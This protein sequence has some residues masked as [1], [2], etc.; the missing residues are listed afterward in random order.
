DY[1]KLDYKVK[2][3]FCI[4]LLGTGNELLGIL[5]L[6][7]GQL[8]GFKDQDIEL[9]KTVA[10]HISIAVERAQERE[11][12]EYKSTVAAQTSWAASIAHEINNE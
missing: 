3:E 6:E 8:N 12:L 7:K 4:S 10:Q 2:S 1:L 9:I 5:A 11:E